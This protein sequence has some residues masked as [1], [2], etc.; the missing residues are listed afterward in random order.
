MAA[1]KKAKTKVKRK[2]APA[3]K[4]AARKKSVKKAGKKAARKKPAVRRAAPR[5]KLAARRVPMARPLR[6]PPRPAGAPAPLAG[7]ER[8]G[9]VIHYFSHLSVAVVRLDSG[10]M[11][12]GDTIHITGHTSDFRQRVESMQIEHQPVTEVSAGQEF[13]LRVTDH[14]RDHDAVYKVTG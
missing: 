13:G 3:R 2:K 7:E 4:P 8:I 10:S 1:R 12:V 9:T 11:R 5:K 14:A 6:M